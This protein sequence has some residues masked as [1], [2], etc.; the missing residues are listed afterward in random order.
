VT[1]EDVLAR[2]VRPGSTVA[3]ADGASSPAGLAGP[4]S[5][6]ARAV[7]GVRLLLGWT[8]SLPAELDLSAFAD[9]RTYL[10]ANALRRS[11]GD[12]LLRYVPVRLG[13]LPALLAGPWRPDVLV[14]SAR[15]G[16]S[17]LTFGAE[18]G[19][20]RAAAAAA[21]T[22]VVELDHALPHATRS[23]ELSE[24]DVLVAAETARG[25]V[26]VPS[27]APDAT[28]LGERVAA[29]IP[30]GAAVQYGPGVV[31]EAALRALRVPVRIDSGLLTDAVVDLDERGLLQGDPTAAYLVGT[32]RLY[33]WA[34][35]RPVLTG[36]EETHDIGRLEKLP[37]VAVNTALE[38]DL[39]GQVNV[40]RAGSRVV[41]GLGGHPDYAA[42]AARSARGLSIVALPT[43]RGGRSTLVE[44]LA[45]PAST[46]RS[47]VDVVVTE[48]GHA[49]LRG[50]DDAERAAALAPLWAGR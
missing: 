18:V 10:A 32:D 47:D 27:P 26:Q 40:E 24:R 8:L 7:G 38:V 11:V 43:V 37:L 21:G 23:D 4:L 35:G 39:A 50:L 16:R 19:W 2:G 46:A 33:R 31:G 22:V 41:A 9:V 44:R 28:G 17:G 34:H 30:A 15:P 42:A 14:A 36:V 45:V 12:G 49:D 5:A 1:A 29:L 20:M 48:R 3:F 25:P 6:V 13:A